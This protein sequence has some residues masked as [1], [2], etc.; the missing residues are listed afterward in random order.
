[1][2]T[3]SVIVTESG[4]QWPGPVEDSENIV[5]VGYDDDGVIQRT[6]HKVDALQRQGRCVRVAVLACNEATDFASVARRAVVAHELLAAVRVVTSGHLVLA[7]ADD[8]SMQ[9]RCE[10]VPLAGALSDSL[11][12]T[13]ATVSVRFGGGADRREEERAG[14]LSLRTAPSEGGRDFQMPGSI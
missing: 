6:R 12:G 5:I 4:S 2:G 1:M 13:S 9:L 3:V 10:L 7:C 14:V 8:V 11:R